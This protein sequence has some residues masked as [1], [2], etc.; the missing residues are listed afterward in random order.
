MVWIIGWLPCGY[1]NT[2]VLW[3]GHLLFFMKAG[4]L[5]YTELFNV[6]AYRPASVDILG[7][8]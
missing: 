7:N 6:R 8:L 3:L 4:A 1:E 2:Y 5:E